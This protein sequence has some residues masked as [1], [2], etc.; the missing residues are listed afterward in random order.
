MMLYFLIII[1]FAFNGWMTWAAASHFSSQEQV[2]KL[3][4]QID[5][6]IKKLQP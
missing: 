5:E 3:Q 2:K 1:V 4:Q 6:L